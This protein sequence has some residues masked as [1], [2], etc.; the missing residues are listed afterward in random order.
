MG[1][2]QHTTRKNKNGL[3]KLGTAVSKLGSNMVN[4]GIGLFAIQFD[5][6][7]LTVYGIGRL[8]QGHSKLVG[9]GLSNLGVGFFV[10]NQVVVNAQPFTTL[11]GLGQAAMGVGQLIEALQ[12]QQQHQGR[13]RR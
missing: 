6:T 11:I 2:R 10:M 4:V 1:E 3:S 9:N 7:W 5:E 8:V 12:L 13:S